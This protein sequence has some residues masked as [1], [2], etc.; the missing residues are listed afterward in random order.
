MHRPLALGLLAPPRH[1]KCNDFK[2]MD[3]V[4]VTCWWRSHCQHHRTSTT[5]LVVGAKIAKVHNAYRVVYTTVNLADK[6]HRIVFSFTIVEV[7]VGGG[8]GGELWRAGGNPKSSSRKGTK[9]R[10]VVM[11]MNPNHQVK[12]VLGV[13]LKGM[14]LLMMA[15]RGT[16]RR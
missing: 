7:V 8:C 3:Y 2:R 6:Y 11:R 5:G 4:V 16:S 12:N 13:L 14:A 1:P 9:V 10:Q 15:P